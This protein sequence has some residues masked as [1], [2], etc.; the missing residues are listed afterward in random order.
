MTDN[1]QV[2]KVFIVKAAEISHER[3]K[4]ERLVFT[5][6]LAKLLWITSHFKQ[7]SFKIICQPFGVKNVLDFDI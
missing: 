2:H 7:L 6:V 5:P 4:Q 1:Y 3:Q